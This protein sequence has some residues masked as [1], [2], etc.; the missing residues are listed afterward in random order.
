LLKGKFFFICYLLSFYYYYYIPLLLLLI[1]MGSLVAIDN[2][3]DPHSQQFLRGHDMPVSDYLYSLLYT[4]YDLH[5]TL[6]YSL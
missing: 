1:S 3:S 4:L 5:C 6:L 2:I